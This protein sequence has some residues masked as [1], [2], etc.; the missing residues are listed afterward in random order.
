MSAEKEQEITK[1]KGRG[2]PKSTSGATRGRKLKEV[3]TEGTGR[4]Q[5]KREV[6]FSQKDQDNKEDTLQMK[7]EASG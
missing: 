1:P 4:G 3:A 6:K 7:N 2:R 5:R